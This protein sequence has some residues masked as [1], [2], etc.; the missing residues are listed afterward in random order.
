VAKRTKPR[1]DDYVSKKQLAF[2]VTLLTLVGSHYLSWPEQL[3]EKILKLIL[4]YLGAQGTVDL[5][6]ALKGSKTR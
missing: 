4:S 5:A 3:V 2:I 6:L 1:L